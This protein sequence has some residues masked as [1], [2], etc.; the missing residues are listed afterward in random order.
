MYK[1][2]IFI[3]FYQKQFA[4]LLFFHVFTFDLSIIQHYVGIENKIIEKG[5]E[6]KKS[7]KKNISLPFLWG[8]IILGLFRLLS[9]S[10]SYKFLLIVISSPTCHPLTQHN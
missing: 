2:I 7:F 5:S 6:I 4:P 8:I 1:T 9:F 3:Y 10:T